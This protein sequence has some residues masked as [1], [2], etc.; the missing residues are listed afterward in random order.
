MHI[1][2]KYLAIFVIFMAYMVFLSPSIYAQENKTFSKAI[3]DNSFLIEEAY[4]Q[5]SRVVQHIFNG[6]QNFT[7]IKDAV[8][9]FTQEWSLWGIKNQFSY[10]LVYQSFNSGEITGMGDLALNYRYQLLDHDDWCAFAPRFTLY[11]PTGNKDKGMGSG[12]VGFELG[13]PFSKRLTNDFSMHFNVGM[14]LYPGYKVQNADAKEET[15]L[16]SSYFVGGSLI[17]LTSY[18]L[19]FMFEYI[20]RFNGN[21]D[22]NLDLNHETVTVINPGIRYAI[23]IGDLQIVPGLAFPITINNGNST[24]GVFLYLSFEHPF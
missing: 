18:N 12:T 10:T 21:F 1:F 17:W 9:S 20:T 16:L 22:S 23:D 14:T 8:L 7:P 3:E 2:T 11:I 19:N 15:K 13:L 4:N 6:M 5:E 24:S